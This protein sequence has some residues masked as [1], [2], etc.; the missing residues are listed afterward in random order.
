MQSLRREMVQ[1][2]S[3]AIVRNDHLV[4]GRDVRPQP[5]QRGDVLAAVDQVS[6][7]VVL[8]PQRHNA[9]GAGVDRRVGLALGDEL[10][11]QVEQFP[12]GAN[13]AEDGM[14]QRAGVVVRTAAGPAHARRIGRVDVDR[15]FRLIGIVDQRG[16][17]A[18]IAG[19]ERGRQLD[20]H[21]VQRRF[22]DLPAAALAAVPRMAAHARRTASACPA[23]IR[24]RRRSAVG[25]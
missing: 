12:A 4:A 18:G 20:P 5:V 17:D 2:F 15:D 10:G 13:G 7:G 21:D 14:A 8:P 16:R 24:S 23:A 9:R 25:W 22:E 3:S 19:H 11:R 1:R 6:G